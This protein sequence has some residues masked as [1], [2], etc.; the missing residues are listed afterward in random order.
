VVLV[1]LIEI[2]IV[3]IEIKLCKDHLNMWKLL[4]NDTIVDGEELKRCAHIF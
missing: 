1:R 4:N 3:L 2:T